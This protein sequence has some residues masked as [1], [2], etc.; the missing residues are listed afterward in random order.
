MQSSNGPRAL[1]KV[2]LIP[3]ER[4]HWAEGM[5]ADVSLDAPTKTGLRSHRAI[6]G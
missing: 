4:R 6:W 3:E 2:N 1:L 5:G